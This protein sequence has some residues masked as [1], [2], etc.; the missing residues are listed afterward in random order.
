MRLREIQSIIKVNLPKISSVKVD[1]FT[2]GGTAYKKIKD[3][4]TLYEGVISLL[5]LQLFDDEEFI[6]NEENLFVNTSNDIATFDIPKYNIFI[7]VVER[8]VYKS[9]AIDNL[10]S[11][12]LHSIEESEDS[13]VISL[14]NRKLTFEELSEL[15]NTLD[16]TFK[17]MRVLKDF[18]SDVTVSNFDIGS[19]WLILSFISTGA[20]KLFGKLVTLIQRTQVGSRQLKAL[21]LQLESIE[22]DENVRNTIREAQAKA[23]SAIYSKLTEQ[24]LEANNLDTQA[25]ILSQMTKVTENIDKLLSSGVSF[26]ASVSASN[27]IAKTFPTYEEQ[28]TLDQTKILDSIKAITTET[29]EDN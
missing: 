8:I 14:P 22:I 26:E 10:I 5:N 18:Q 20:V 7:D 17:M 11:Q 4:Q 16:N 3:Y 29:Y 15:V 6:A 24:F 25:E 2:R 12:N 23:N 28:K 1:D 9:E 13:L 27:E 21:D 19:Q